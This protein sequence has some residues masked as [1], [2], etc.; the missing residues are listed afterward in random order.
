MSELDIVTL[1]LSLIL[2][3]SI[4]Q[5]LGAVA[6]AIRGRRQH[7]VNWIPIAWATAIFLY[8]VQFWFAIFD[9]GALTTTWSWDWYAPVLLLAVLLF[10]SGSLILPSR[11]HEWAEGM[12]AD[13]EHNGR[14][15]LI[16]AI[17]YVLVWIPVNARMGGDWIH[18]ANILNIVLIALTV[19]AF[20]QRTRRYRGIATVAYVLLV[21]FGMLFVWSR[22]GSNT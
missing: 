19:V 10:L 12:Q 6:A 16:P 2:G 17:L 8:H 20:A 13:F 15:A 1:T 18:P 3:L 5:M 14:L 22:P 11:D 21:V 4:A 7:P 9:I